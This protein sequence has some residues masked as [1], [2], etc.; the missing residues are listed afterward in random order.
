MYGQ[1]S[2]YGDFNNRS[3]N[4][5][6]WVTGATVRGVSTR[7]MPPWGGLKGANMSRQ[8][9]ILG[10][11]MI[12][13]VVAQPAAAQEKAVS[14]TVRGGGFNGLANL[15]DG[16]T[17]DF[18]K[19][20]YN[21]GGGVGVELHRYIALRGDVAFARN[22]LQQNSL[23]TGSELSR[24]FYDGGVQLQYPTASG[25]QPH[26]YVG[27]GA[28]TLHPVGTSDN[29]KTTF[30]GTGGLGLGYTIPGSNFGFLVEGKG[31]VYE[32]NEL[33]G[34]LASFDKTQF[35]VTWSAGF[36]Y[37]IPFG[38]SAARVSR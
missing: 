37:R 5:L 17:A 7:V 31:W 13:L 34:S 4:N 29:D 19:V 22:E 8:A 12:G 33:G 6:R 1:S 26:L 16:G 20:G 30:A 38:S 28:V 25:W 11:L 18:K 21:V 2:N 14:V 10:A 15:N 36:T 23:E 9:R 32:L 27:A 24:L 3:M 35:D